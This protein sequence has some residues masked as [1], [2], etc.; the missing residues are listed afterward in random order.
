MWFSI[1]IFEIIRN[2]YLML[3]FFLV[4]ALHLIGSGDAIHKNTSLKDKS[5][6]Q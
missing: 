4:F 1:K 5:E 2:K 6:V 3:N